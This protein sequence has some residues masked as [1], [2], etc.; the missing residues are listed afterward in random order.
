MSLCLQFTTL[1]I[2]CLS[3]T[4]IASISG[5]IIIVSGQIM[6][7]KLRQLIMLKPFLW[8]Y[9]ATCLFWVFGLIGYS[10]FIALP[11]TRLCTNFVLINSVFG[12][13]MGFTGYLMGLIGTYWIFLL[14]LKYN[15]ESTCLQLS[16][17]TY[18]VLSSGIWIQTV[19]VAVT[20]YYFIT[21]QWDIGLIFS[22]STIIINA[23][24]SLLLMIIFIR[25]L[26]TLQKAKQKPIQIKLPSLRNAALKTDPVRTIENDERV[27]SSVTETTETRHRSHPLNDLAEMAVKY[28]ICA[29]IAF[30]SS[31]LVNFMSFYRGILT[32]D[33]VD[34]LYIHVALNAL[35]CLITIICL[36]LQFIFAQKYY[37][38]LCKS[39]RIKLKSMVLKHFDETR[40]VKYVRKYTNDDRTCNVSDDATKLQVVTLTDTITFEH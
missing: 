15:F 37:M 32:E 8:L 17:C 13:G 22:Y 4:G 25:N 16:N 19:L 11:Y 26:F 33:T 36:H 6:S 34:L 12:V 14:R 1:S 28:G 40:P 18:H 38:V 35:D 30:S 27:T 24:Y 2:I 7:F 29:F 31:I 10:L 3:V 21:F 5:I 9:R 39:L 23:L 20:A